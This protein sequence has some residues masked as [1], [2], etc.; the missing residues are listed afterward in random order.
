M[1]KSYPP[2]VVVDENDHEVGTAMLEEAW[3]K[4]LYHRVSAVHV[5]DDRGRLLLQLRSPQVKIYP[6]RWDQAAGGHV[7]EGYSY[8]QTAI[9]ELAEEVGIHNVELQPVG[10]F[11]IHERLSEGR[12]NNQFERV[13]V[14]RIPHD[15][16]LKPQLDEV[17]ELRWFTGAELKDQLSAN[18]EQFT[19]GLLYILQNYSSAFGL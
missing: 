4:G 19:P 8:K 3:Q 18:R 5:Q 2:V 14:V 7:D 9:K 11:Y 15:T 10:T 6:G 12:I 1:A 13:Y 16:P 17:S